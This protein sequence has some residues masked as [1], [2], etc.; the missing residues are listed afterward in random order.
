MKTLVYDNYSKFIAASA[1]IRNMRS[2]VESMEDEMSR[3]VANIG[4]ISDSSERIS[5]TLAAK[6]EAIEQL[7]GVH[8]LLRKLQFLVQLPARLRHSIAMQ[9]YVE[10]VSY[11]SKT[12]GILER[13]R[14]FPSFAPI[15]LQVDQIISDLKSVLDSKLAFSPDMKAVDIGTTTRLLLDLRLP[16]RSLRQRYID[17]SWSLIMSV[18][19]PAEEVLSASTAAAVENGSSSSASAA[20]SVAPAASASS[21]VALLR[22]GALPTS[23]PTSTSQSQSARVNAWRQL[24]ASERIHKVN[25]SLSDAF[26][27]LCR[28]YG[29]NFLS[30]Q[31]PPNADVK[32]TADQVAHL[33]S[34]SHFVHAVLARYVT[35]CDKSLLASVNDTGLSDPVNADTTIEIAALVDKGLGIILSSFY[36][37]MALATCAMIAK[38]DEG[39]MQYVAAQSEWT[40]QER[41][42][43][44]LQQPSHYLD[45]VLFSLLRFYFGQAEDSLRASIAQLRQRLLTR[46]EQGQSLTAESCNELINE[47]S[48]SIC[49][50]L[51]SIFSGRIAPLAAALADGRLGSA[52]LF[53]S[54]INVHIISLLRFLVSTLQS[55]TE[56]D[57]QERQLRPMLL[58]L[59]LVSR[60]LFSDLRPLLQ[61]TVCGSILRD[62]EAD[63]VLVMLDHFSAAS[64]QI[65]AA[66][67]QLEGIK[68][69]HRIRI[70]IEATQWTSIREPST[71]DT[72][73]KAFVVELREIQHILSVLVPTGAD[74][75]GPVSNASR[76]H[77]EDSLDGLF[78]RKASYFGKITFQPKSILSAVARLALKSLLEAVRCQ[79]FE[80][81]GYQQ[82][83][84]DCDVL[85]RVLIDFV[86][87]SQLL[88][89]ITSDIM[90]AAKERALDPTPLDGTVMAKLTAEIAPSL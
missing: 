28:L 42:A 47:V 14:H 10:A 27:E 89:A 78:A 80:R 67:V 29:M 86:S 43:P 17:L 32:V 20:S 88:S 36:D 30:G 26:G 51:E 60:R 11:Y 22:S 35:L 15:A 65:L 62:Q 5:G 12:S 71:V 57:P 7:S 49:G 3:L 31:A 74:S 4:K 64:Q 8:H 45:G 44:Q 9:N 61:R 85:A 18:L 76:G 66:Y 56:H 41:S 70:A 59:C 82:I 25:E 1:T 37:Q 50:V 77:A 72:W 54:Q 16:A 40:L 75:E 53:G 52:K 79:V 13:Y 90:N 87:D 58:L 23:R 2:K 19:K 81:N 63:N 39:V 24:T 33:N 68:L 69:G 6:R 83:T 48:H 55:Y 73:V 21:K 38:G 84:L 34:L 46:E